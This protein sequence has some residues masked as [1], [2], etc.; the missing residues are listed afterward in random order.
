VILLHFLITYSLERSQIIIVFCA[1]WFPVPSA[2]LRLEEN[3]TC[4]FITEPN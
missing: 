3:V 1:M 4:D 2:V